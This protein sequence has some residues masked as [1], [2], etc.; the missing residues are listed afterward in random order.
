MAVPH[1]C[2]PKPQVAGVFFCRWETLEIPGFYYYSKGRMGFDAQETGK[3]FCLF[4]VF[5]PG[6]KFPNT[7][8]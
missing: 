4:T 1:L 8:I 6:G 2:D 3:L 5:L 7:P